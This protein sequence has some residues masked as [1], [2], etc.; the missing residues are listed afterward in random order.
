MMV[1]LEYL[2]AVRTENAEGGVRGGAEGGTEGGAESAAAHASLS[3]PLVPPV[4]RLVSSWLAQPSAAEAM[5]LYDR[6]CSLLPLLRAAA[7]DSTRSVSGASGGTPGLWA[8]H[9]QAFKP[10]ERSPPSE[11]AA[12]EAAEAE[13]TMADLFDRL[14]PRGP[15]ASQP[16]GAAGAQ[17]QEAQMQRL[18]EMLGRAPA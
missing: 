6:A 2:E 11:E 15:H 16:P 12:K 14:M 10:E 9:L 3:H 7:A 17:M 18:A 8:R 13:G 5:E 4:A 1:S